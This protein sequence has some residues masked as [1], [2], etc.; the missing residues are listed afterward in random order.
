MLEQQ[1]WCIIAK[2]FI[3]YRISI[4]RIRSPS[5]GTP[6][7]VL[8]PRGLQDP[9]SRR[10][11]A[12]LHPPI[13]TSLPPIPARLPIPGTRPSKL[14]IL[15]QLFFS[16]D[17]L[18]FTKLVRDLCL[19]VHYSIRTRSFAPINLQPHAS[20]ARR[21]FCSAR[22]KVANYVRHYSSTSTNTD[23]FGNIL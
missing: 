20:H 23:L 6:S 21:P 2:I 12:C 13:I 15:G 14:P 7:A 16:S 19:A 10:H 11:R 17:G 5:F 8:L 22:G 1:R 18:R 4:T 3:Y 9:N